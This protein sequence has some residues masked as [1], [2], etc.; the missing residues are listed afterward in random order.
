MRS[1][2]V[3]DAFMTDAA[4]EALAQQLR[5]AFDRYL[6]APALTVLNPPVH[7]PER[8]HHAQNH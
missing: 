2:P 1:D 4:M 6:A 7:R 8:G 5:D 3:F